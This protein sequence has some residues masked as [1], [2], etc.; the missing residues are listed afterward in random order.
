MKSKLL[1]AL[2]LLFVAPSLFA[3]THFVGFLEHSEENET[4]TIPAHGYAHLI[5]SEDRSRIDYTVAVWKTSDEPTMAHFHTGARRM[6]GPPVK[7]FT[8]KNGIVGTG[9]WSL[10]DAD[11]PLT[12]ELVDSLLQGKLYVNIHTLN[13]PGGE[14]RSQLFQPQ[15]W[16]F[17][18]TADQENPDR[19]SD[20]IRSAA[21]GVVVRDPIHNNIFYRITASNVMSPVTMAHIHVGGRD[22]SGP[23]V[24]TTPVDSGTLTATSYW[25]PESTTEPFTN[26]H[27]A[28]LESGRLYWN[29]HTQNHQPGEIRGQIENPGTGH[30][31][32]ALLSGPTEAGVIPSAAEGTA[33]MYLSPTLDTFVTVVTASGLSGPILDGHIHVGR[34]DVAG[35]PVIHLPKTDYGLASFWTKE[36]LERPFTRAD[37]DS[38]FSGAYYVNLHTTKYP[39]GEIRGQIIPL[40]QEPEEASVTFG[41]RLGELGLAASSNPARGIT[42]VSYELPY[43]MRAEIELY[44]VTGKRLIRQIEDGG[45]G[46]NRCQLKLHDVAPGAYQVRLNAGGESSTLSL[47][48]TK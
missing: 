45:K 37:V 18:A 43:P 24:R 35:P 3:Q 13:N 39:G 12:S 41:E 30:I 17:L 10:N 33:L 44:D 5:L 29:L 31:F 4:F 11:D 36:D 2:A 27:L 19:G 23:P 25:S 32:M 48:V 34:G 15:A 8:L 26:A 22:T 46:I 7:T 47:I 1:I 42:T 20:T 16:G 6:D 40:S 9:T 28:D 14:I 21:V 38:L